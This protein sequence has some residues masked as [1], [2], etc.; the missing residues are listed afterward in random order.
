[1]EP[2]VPFVWQLAQLAAF[3]L[4]TPEGRPVVLWQGAQG[5]LC[6][7]SVTIPAPFDPTAPIPAP[8]APGD[9]VPGWPRCLFF[10]ADDVQIAGSV[11]RWVDPADTKGARGPLAEITWS[12]PQHG[13]LVVYP[14]PPDPKIKPKPGAELPPPPPPIAVALVLPDVARAPRPAAAQAWPVALTAAPPP[15]EGAP[16]PPADAPP[17]VA[18][19]V[20]WTY[21]PTGAVTASLPVPFGAAALPPLPRPPPPKPAPPPPATKPPLAERAETIVPGRWATAAR[22]CA[23]EKPV[24]IFEPLL[25]AVPAPPPPGTP[26]PKPPPKPK[27]GEAP[28]P[29]PPPP[30]P[31]TLVY[32]VAGSWAVAAEQ[33]TCQDAGARWVGVRLP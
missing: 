30:A 23:R 3:T 29:P 1:M 19:E 5:A 9:P 15:V 32:D 22:D 17:F 12:D 16:P 28:P 27:P 2:V 18:P 20:Q 6:P 25:V 13:A 4:T 11:W 8:P 31:V 7:P 10:D 24:W 33:T 26:A 21:A 14:D